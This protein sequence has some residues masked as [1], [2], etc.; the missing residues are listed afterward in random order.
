MV[1]RARLLEVALVFLKL[2]T[3][4]FGG[5]AAHIGLLRDEVVRRR[6]WLSDQ[7]FLDLLG[8]ANLIPGPNSTEMTIF[9][10]AQRAGWRGLIIGGVCFVVPA[11]FIVMIFGWLYVQFGSLPQLE[12]LLYGVKPVMI[13]IIVQAV[14]ELGKKAV[15][16]PLTLSVGLLALAWYVLGAAEIPLLLAGGLLVMLIQNR[17]RLRARLCGRGSAP[18]GLLLG[19]LLHPLASAAAQTAVA[20]QTTAAAT[21]S[22]AQLFWSFFKIGAVLYGSG[23][24]LI[25]FMQTEFVQHLGWLTD[26]QLLD[27]IVVG[28][29]TPGPLFTSATFVGFMLGGVPGAVIATIAI[30]LPA[31]M[32]VA[33]V[34]PFVP[35]LRQSPW[36]SALLDG[37][38]VVSLALVVGVAF[39]LARVSLLD[40]LTIAL[41][42]LSLVVLLRFKLNSIW[43]VLGGA[44]MGLLA[45]TLR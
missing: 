11:M 5:P 19:G 22:Y 24:V 17:S 28:Q 20:A 13:A 21:F 18:T 38:N 41:G 29:I 45:F 39:D 8:A 32:L 1:D 31:F 3:L 4:A 10:G 14:W 44:L 6:R 9:L 2:G 33:L 27:A 30:F 42:F 34:R 23:Y 7:E 25:A 26:Q 15:K 43:L 12:W 16:G 36:L 35:R 40:P 37:V